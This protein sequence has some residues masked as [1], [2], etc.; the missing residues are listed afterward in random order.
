MMHVVKRLS[1][2]DRALPVAVYGRSEMLRQ[3]CEAAGATEYI[4]ET[5]SREIGRKV[6][7]MLGVTV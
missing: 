3:Q 5:D 2:N 4:E 6:V 7:T 1:T